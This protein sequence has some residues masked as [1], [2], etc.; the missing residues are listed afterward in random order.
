VSRTA[1]ECESNGGRMGVELQSNVSRTAVE[2][3]PNRSR[4]VVLTLTFHIKNSRKHNRL[5]FTLLTFRSL[6]DRDRNVNNVRIIMACVLM[7]FF[8]YE[9]F[10]NQM[11]LLMYVSLLDEASCLHYLSLL[12]PQRIVE[13]HCL[14][15]IS[16][17]RSLR[18]RSK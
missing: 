8:N 13:N 10:I 1:V 2:S 4:I 3:Q 16:T 17:V 5:F 12:P 9:T 7:I 15:Q 11:T 18:T 6:S 14:R